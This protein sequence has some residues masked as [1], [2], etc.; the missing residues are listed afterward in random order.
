MAIFEDLH[1]PPSTAS[2]MGVADTFI[3]AACVSQVAGGLLLVACWS[4]AALPPGAPGWCASV[5]SGVVGFR[6]ACC[7]LGRGRVK[8]ATV[9][10]GTGII[11][12]AAVLPPSSLWPLLP[13]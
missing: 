8:D 9:A 13:L 6:Y 3:V 2:A 4:L 1:F 5:A 7:G 10:G 12:S 11:H